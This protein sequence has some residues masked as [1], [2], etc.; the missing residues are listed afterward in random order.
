[1]NFSAD[2]L[3][4]LCL[5]AWREARNQGSDGIRAVMHVVVNRTKA[6]YHQRQDPLHD[7]IYAKNQFTSMSV[8][9]DPE[10]HLQ[11]AAGDAQYAYCLGIAPDVLAETDPDLT[12]GARY[13]ADLKYVTSGWFVTSIVNCPD[14]HPQTAVIGKQT[15]YR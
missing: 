4:N 7:C 8:S 15:F 14:V 1:M 9:S 6:W 5:C 12:N 13:Y 10:Y 2:D 11:P 3:D